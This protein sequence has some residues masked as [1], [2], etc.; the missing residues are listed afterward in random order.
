M[1]KLLKLCGKKNP[2]KSA[3]DRKR[4]YSQKKWIYQQLSTGLSDRL[5]TIHNEFLPYYNGI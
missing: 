2:A 1:D 4:I 3:V 5:S